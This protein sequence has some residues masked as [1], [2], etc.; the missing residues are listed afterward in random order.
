MIS[1]QL[2]SSRKFPPLAGH[3]RLLFR[4][5]VIGPCAYR[6]RPE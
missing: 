2:Y 3:P 1:Y 5:P 6:T 4:P